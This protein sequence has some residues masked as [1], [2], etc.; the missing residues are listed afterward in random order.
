M[1]H[2][3]RQFRAVGQNWRGHQKRHGGCLLWAVWSERGSGW[4]FIQTTRS[5]L[6]T[7]GLDCHRALQISWCVLKEE[8]MW[9]G[10][11]SQSEYPG[12]IFLPEIP[13]K[14]SRTGF[15]LDMLHTGRQV[16]L[17]NAIADVCLSCRDHQWELH[18]EG[19]WERKV[20]EEKSGFQDSILRVIQ[21]REAVLSWKNAQKTSKIYKDKLLSA[22]QGSFPMCRTSRPVRRLVQLNREFQSELY[23]KIKWMVTDWN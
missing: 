17:G 13:N 16:L 19:K 7:A 4:S 3:R 1:N 23:H 2:A 20:A 9:K 10:V 8:Q 21:G 15:L 11:S 22:S 18:A 14:P 6:T 12:D 5:H